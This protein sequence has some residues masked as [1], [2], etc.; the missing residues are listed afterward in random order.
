MI[1]SAG[2]ILYSDIYPLDVLNPQSDPEI[3]AWLVREL[4]SLTD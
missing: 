3:R 2:F 1:V 4:Q